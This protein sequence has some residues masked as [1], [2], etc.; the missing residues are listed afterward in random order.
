VFLRDLESRGRTLLDELRRRP[1][2]SA[3]QA[4]VRAASADV[5]AHARE[6]GVADVPGRAPVPGDVVEVAGRGIRGE[7]VEIAGD[8][9][10]IQRGGLRFEVPAGQLRVVGDAPA[11]E[12]VAVAVERP[13]NAAEE[14]NLIGRRTREAIEELAAFLDRAARAGLGEVRVVHGIGSGA[15]RRAIHEYL[16]SSPYCAAFRDSDPERGGAAV[17]IAELA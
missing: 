3:L 6:T 16:G 14:I 10:R 9:A 7:L 4:F 17:T 2:A 13:A 1:D 11:A 5:D 8:R 12:R 15:L